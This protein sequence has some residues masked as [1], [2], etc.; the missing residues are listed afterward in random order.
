MN[1]HMNN[2]QKPDDTYKYV[3]TRITEKPINN[4]EPTI[5]NMNEA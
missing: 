5:M 1:V 3:K 4:N 2:T